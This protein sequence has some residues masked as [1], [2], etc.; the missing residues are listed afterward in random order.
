VHETVMRGGVMKMRSVE[1][2]EIPPGCAVMLE[3]GGRH[4]MM[5]R[6]CQNLSA[7]NR[8]RDAAISR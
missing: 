5:T 2:I 1:T 6:R 4:L 8:L 7:R 3:P